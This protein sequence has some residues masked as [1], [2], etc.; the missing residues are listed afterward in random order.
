MI[1]FALGGEG[2]WRVGHG[3]EEMF[4]GGKATVGSLLRGDGAE[5]AVHD[6]CV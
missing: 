2:E 1:V 6:G 5:E 4:F 3:G